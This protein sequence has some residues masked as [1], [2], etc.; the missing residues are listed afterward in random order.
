M[1]I[2]LT[3]KTTSFKGCTFITG[4]HGIGETG[5]ISVSYIIQVL[6]A[7]RIGFIE[8]NKPPPFITASESGLI[9]PF[10][11]YKQ[12]KI[13]LLKLEFPPNKSEETQILKLISSW[14]VQKKFKEAKII[15]LVKT[16]AV[17]T[18]YN[19]Y[20]IEGQKITDRIG[21]VTFSLIFYVIYTLWYG[22]GIMYL[23]EGVGM[24]LEH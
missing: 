2:N 22:F 21:V 9:T 4:F 1:S 3:K 5:Y 14:V 6:N 18:S 15:D 13:V 17:E 12:G 24:Q 16:K 20:G 11:L 23:F 8:A 10:E 7:S 19:Y